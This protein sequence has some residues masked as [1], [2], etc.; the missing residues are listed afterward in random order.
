MATTDHTAPLARRIPPA[1]PPSVTAP[2]AYI[3]DTVEEPCRRDA[4]TD[5]KLG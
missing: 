1:T 3:A 4:V 2:S 5:E